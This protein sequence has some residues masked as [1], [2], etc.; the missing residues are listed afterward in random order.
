MIDSM[1]D[2]LM[3]RLASEG[4]SAEDWAQLIRALGVQGDLDRARTIF[5]EAQ[6][7]FETR[8]DDLA[9]VTAAAAQAGLAGDSAAPTAAPT[10][11]ARTATLDGIATRLSDELATEGGPPEKWVQLIEALGELGE[12]ERAAAIWREAQ[13]AFADNS[14]A[15]AIVRQAAIAAGVAE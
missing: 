2:G 9:L 8:P 6:T 12:P 3:Q 4:G 1:V 7:V 10:D 15:L 11:D 14:E 5:A 13:N